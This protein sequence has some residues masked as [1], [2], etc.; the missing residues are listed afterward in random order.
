MGEKNNFEEEKQQPL[1]GK[2]Y[3]KTRLD[4]MSL[5]DLSKLINIQSSLLNLQSKE[6]GKV[7]SALNTLSSM[8]KFAGRKDALY[9]LVGY[10]KIEIKSMDDIIRFFDRTQMASSKD[11]SWMILNDMVKIKEIARRVLFVRDFIPHLSLVFRDSNEDKKK[12]IRNLIRDSVWGDKLK[13][14]FLDKLFN[15]SYRDGLF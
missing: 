14:R 10:Y 1:T 13:R 15:Q 8:V 11:L 5:N 4:K 9:V 2:H 7:K 6:A 12:E 3:I